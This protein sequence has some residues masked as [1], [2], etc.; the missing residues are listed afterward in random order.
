MNCQINLLA[1]Q[2]LVYKPT[3]FTI[4]MG[5]LVKSPN[6]PKRKPIKETPPASNEMNK[7]MLLIFLCVCVFIVAVVDQFVYLLLLVYKTLILFVLSQL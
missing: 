5:S 3:L 6:D 1:C 2:D 7:F 4:F